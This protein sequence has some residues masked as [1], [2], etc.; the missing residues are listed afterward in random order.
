[1]LNRIRSRL[2]Y[3]NVVATLAMFIALGGGAYAL[4]GVPDRSGTYHGC[5]SASGV[6]RV[7]RSASSCHRAKTV[8]RDTRRV[9]VPGESAISWHQTGPRGPQGVPGNPGNPGNPGQNAA[10]HV[11]VRRATNGDG[12]NFADVSCNPGEV[13]TGGGGFSPAGLTATEPS[14]ATAGATPV[15][16]SALTNGGQPPGTMLVF[17]ICSS[18]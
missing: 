16:W 13:A 17:A 12:Q 9:R 18:P 8:E 6:L 7:V 14:P 5:V 11:V 1:M 15:G 4:N 3:A 2:T 10:T